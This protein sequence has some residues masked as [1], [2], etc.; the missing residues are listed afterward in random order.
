MALGHGGFLFLRQAV[1]AHVSTFIF[2]MYT[3]QV[4]L[5][6]PLCAAHLG[7]SRAQSTGRGCHA[8]RPSAS[9][10]KAAYRTQ[11]ARQ[12]SPR[13][14]SGRGKRG[15]GGR[16]ELVAGTQEAQQHTTNAQET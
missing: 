11:G 4:L 16:R 12:V 5:C 3:T 8:F 6:V 10:T 2:L 9:S 1:R 13:T 15:E 7:L 14:R